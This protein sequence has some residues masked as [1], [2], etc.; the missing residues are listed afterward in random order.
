MTHFLYENACSEE[1]VLS[2]IFTW[3]GSDYVKIYNKNSPRL[4]HANVD[5]DYVIK[6][7][8]VPRDAHFIGVIRNPLE[9]QLSLYLQRIVE[10]KYSVKTPSPKHFKT[11]VINGIFQDKEPQGLPQCSFISKDLKHTYWLHDCIE[12]HLLDFCSNNSI[13]IKSELRVIS[14]SPGNT[15]ELIKVFYDDELLKQVQD[16][17]KED[18]ALYNSLLDKYSDLLLR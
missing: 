3:T 17:Y 13:P 6:H 16:M 4:P 5:S 1:D 2:K 7:N 14:R 10:G 9:R 11:L 12:K 15:K 8:I 18:F